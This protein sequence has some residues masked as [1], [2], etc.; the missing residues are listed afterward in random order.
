MKPH[1]ILKPFKG[2]QTG[3]D[4]PHHFTPGDEPVLLSDYLADI[5]VKAGWA[6]PHKEG[7][8]VAD[9]AIEETVNESVEEKS[10]DEAPE[11]KALKPVKANKGKK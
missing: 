9:E 2:S 5:V 11:N 6:L 7:D 1:R 8:S 10:L 4:G 3:S